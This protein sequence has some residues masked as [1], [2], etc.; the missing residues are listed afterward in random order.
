MSYSEWLHAYALPLDSQAHYAG[1]ELAFR[2]FQTYLQQ[3]KHVRR[4]QVQ[5][6]GAESANWN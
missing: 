6:C 2:K 5:K 1:E 4:G 3:S